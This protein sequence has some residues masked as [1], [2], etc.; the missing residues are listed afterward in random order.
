MDDIGRDALTVQ[1]AVC[2]IPSFTMDGAVADEKVEYRERGS[3]ES[4]L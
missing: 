1:H 3:I 4:L 2:I